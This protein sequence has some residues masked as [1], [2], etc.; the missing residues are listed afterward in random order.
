MYQTIGE[1]SKR[2][3]GFVYYNSQHITVLRASIQ[4]P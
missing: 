2:Q 3:F 1:D 4:L